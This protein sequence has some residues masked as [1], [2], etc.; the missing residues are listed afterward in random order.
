MKFFFVDCVCYAIRATVE[1]ETKNSVKKK[2]KSHT[3]ATQ[4][5]TQGYYVTA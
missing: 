5:C 2:K 3:N 1:C 4:K